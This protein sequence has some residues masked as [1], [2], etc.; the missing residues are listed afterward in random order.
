MEIINVILCFEQQ[1]RF[2]RDNEWVI[3]SFRIETNLDQKSHKNR[4]WRK[5]VGCSDDWSERQIAAFSKINRLRKRI[6][7]PDGFGRKSAL[8]KKLARFFWREN[9]ISSMDQSNLAK[10]DF[11]VFSDPSNFKAL[12]LFSRVRLKLHQ[13]FFCFDMIILVWKFSWFSH[14]RFWEA[15]LIKLH[16][17]SWI[18]SFR[19]T[20]IRSWMRPRISTISRRLNS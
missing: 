12:D 3:E 10:L 20:M 11:V 7:H 6:N 2:T 1:I 18:S 4:F 16:S 8:K 14:G 17:C 5:Q 19:I 13:A 9:F 15:S